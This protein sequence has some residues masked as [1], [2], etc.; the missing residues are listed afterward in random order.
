MELKQQSVPV[1]KKIASIS[2]IQEML[3]KKTISKESLPKTHKFLILLSTYPMSLATAERTF[4]VMRQIKTWLRSRTGP[5]VLTNYMFAV[6]HKQRMDDV[7]IQN[8]YQSL[9]KERLWKFLI[10]YC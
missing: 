5:G 1:I 4:S 6:I 7:D 9:H 2:T 8:L 10:I 3:N